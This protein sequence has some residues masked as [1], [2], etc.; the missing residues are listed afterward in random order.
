VTS[1]EQYWF[2]PF[3]LDVAEREL[4]RGG[5]VVALTA[6]TFDLI[7]PGARCR[8]DIHEIRAA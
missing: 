4:R 2:G 7:D 8:L 6:K 3:Q 1:G 5:E